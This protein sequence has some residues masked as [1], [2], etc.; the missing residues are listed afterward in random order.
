LE[1]SNREGKPEGS[2]VRV[3][4]N[5]GEIGC[6]TEK[7]IPQPKVNLTWGGGVGEEKSR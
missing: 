3:E 6:E 1:H 4:T 5:L 2:D 7:N